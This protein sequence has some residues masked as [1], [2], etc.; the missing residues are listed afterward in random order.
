MDDQNNAGATAQ[1]TV[2]VIVAGRIVGI[3][4]NAAY[5][6]AKDGSLPSFRVAGQIRVPTAKLGAMLGMPDAQLALAI[7]RA[8]AASE[9]AAA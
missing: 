3:G 1:P 4:K 7:A 6:A 2:D 9:P 5:K 8:S